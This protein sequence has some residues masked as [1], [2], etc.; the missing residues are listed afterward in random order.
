[1]YEIVTIPRPDAFKPRYN[2]A[3]LAE[4]KDNP[5]ACFLVPLNGTAIDTIR[6]RIT[7]ELKTAQKYGLCPGLDA[8]DCSVKFWRMI[9][10][11]RCTD[12]RR[13]F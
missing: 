6:K 7:G 2:F 13:E 3:G 5:D 10:R 4:Q 9:S 1:M 8:V 12:M 11:K